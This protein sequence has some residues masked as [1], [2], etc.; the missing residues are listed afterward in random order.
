VTTCANDAACGAGKY[1]GAG[2]SCLACSTSNPARCGTAASAA[3][4]QA[5]SG[6]TPV[7]TAGAC[8][9]APTACTND[10]GCANGK[11]CGPGGSC[12]ACSDSDRFRCGTAATAAGCQRCD[13]ICNAG[14]CVACTSNTQCGADGPCTAGKCAGAG[15][16]GAA[17]TA[18]GDCGGTGAICDTYVS[19]GY[20]LQP[21]TAGGTACPTGS[22]CLS[23]NATAAY[24][25]EGQ[26]QTDAECSRRG[27]GFVCDSDKSCWS[28]NYVPVNSGADAAGSPCADGD[29]CESGICIPATSGTTST[30]YAGGYCTSYCKPEVAGSCPPDAV[31][32]NVAQFGTTLCMQACSGTCTRPGYS[33]VDGACVPTPTC[34]DGICNGGESSASCCDDCGC[35]AGQTC[36]APAGGGAKSCTT[37]N[38]TGKNPGEACAA[39]AECKGEGS[40][41]VKRPGGYC[42]MLGCTPGANGTSDCPS[43]STCVS[44]GQD[45]QG[46]TIYVCA[47]GPCATDA[48][49]RQSEGY[50]CD[51]DHVCW[52]YQYVPVNTGGAAMGAA[53]TDNAQCESGV[54]I[55][56]S[57]NV[58]YTGGYCS[59][60]CV[61]T[62]AGSCPTG[63]ACVDQSAVF[64]V[65]ICAKNCTQNSDCRTGY[66]CTAGACLPPAPS[67]GDGTCSASETQATCCED[68]GCPA[69]Q[70][71]GTDHACHA[72][73]GSVPAGGACTQDS[74]CTGT[75]AVCD[76]YLPGGYCLLPCATDNDCAA[77]SYCQAFDGG[78]SYCVEGRCAAD[79]DCS[80]QAAGY[81]CLTDYGLC[82]SYAY[83]DVNP[84]GADAGAAC[85]AGTG[86]KSDVCIPET[87]EGS[88]TGY[89]G[90]YC[91]AVCRSGVAASCPTGT[92]CVDES[93]QLGAWICEK[94][95][96]ANTDCRTGYACTGGVCTPAGTTPGGSPPG[97]ACTADTDCAGTGATCYRHEIGGY[98]YTT[99]CAAGGSDCPAGSFC[100]PWSEDAQGNTV[101]AC[102]EGQCTTDADCNRRNEGYICD[103]D[104]TCWSYL[105]AAVNT[106]GAAIGAACAD[107]AACESDIC[108]PETYQGSPTGYAGGYCLVGC[109]NGVAGNC[110][111]GSKCVDQS[112]EFGAWVC[113]KTCTTNAECRTGYGC[114]AGACEPGSGTAPVCGDNACNG[115]ETQ[116]TC[117]ED[118]GCPT[119]QNCGTDHACHAAGA[120][121]TAPGGACTQDSD[122]AGTG[123]KCSKYL[124]GGYCLIPCTAGGTA[125]PSG[126]FCLQFSSTSS[127]CVEGQC[128]NDSDCSRQNEGYICD[129]DHSCW[130][131]AYVVVNPSGSA[132]GAACTDDAGC[133]SG[134]CLT[135]DYGYTGGYCTAQCVTTL[136]SSCPTGSTCVDDPYLGPLCETSCTSTANCRSGYTCNTSGGCEPQ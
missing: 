96:A 56:E 8:T 47:A 93:A 90:G 21:C 92:V 94:A 54:C 120:G 113:E 16:P 111:T 114:T 64:G 127:Y 69:G 97:G 46:N 122:C 38:P 79:S 126:S 7:C 72:G 110:P 57:W 3:G 70:N 124:T 39:D 52:S 37:T 14:A 55:A 25:V 105:Y 68:C 136:A 33:C 2:G 98:C 129:V 27:E 65:S 132:V 29:A 100:I 86:C 82:W 12:L 77:G 13:G 87:Y 88:P 6:A 10:A 32:T 36:A 63:S 109:K 48:E 123:A 15:R 117:C 17:C 49:C 116:A 45:D 62:T 76:T 125:C 22:F 18:D 11:Y 31:C 73:G 28:Y 5:C 135:D 101:N 115:T 130:S 23:F 4:C 30:G 19:G 108:V 81:T 102:V 134:L 61:A 104:G 42:L 89:P 26:C 78:V 35:G 44:G 9:A 91:T 107:D 34:G 121:T 20:C 59:V 131:Y 71:C 128:Q 51:T 95:C 74:Q 43:G 1:C 83:T 24:C 41:C 40:I 84:N 99:G 80:R 118:C 112:A 53:C 58:G 67:C 133:Q 60:G 103:T 66:V 119:G 50:V 106:G 75:G 85:T